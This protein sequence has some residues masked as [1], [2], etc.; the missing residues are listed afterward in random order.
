MIEWIKKYG[1]CLWLGIAMAIADIPV[2]NWKWWVIVIPAIIL[3]G[4]AVDYNENK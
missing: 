4:M 2:T 3:G 1:W